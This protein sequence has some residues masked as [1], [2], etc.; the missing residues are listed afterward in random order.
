MIRL[1]VVAVCFLAA[2]PGAFGQPNHCP[3]GPAGWI[4][5]RNSG[6]NV[7][8]PCPQNDES[9]TWSGSCADGVAEGTGVLQWFLGAK[10]DQRYAGAV[11]AGRP[12]GRGTY[13]WSDGTWYEGEFRDYEMTGHGLM[14]SPNGDWYR[15]EWHDGRANGQGTAQFVDGFT[16]VGIWRD[17]CI[18]KGKYTAWMGSTEEECESKRPEAGSQ[19]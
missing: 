7:W 13:T 14:M 1:L 4:P 3:G 2:V 19:P 16:Y 5:D 8:N 10:V 18:Y 17:G 12:N 9:I 6:C 11:R 15:G